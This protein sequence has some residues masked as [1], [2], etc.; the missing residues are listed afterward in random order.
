MLALIKDGHP[1]SVKFNVT[2]NMY[3]QVDHF[4]I[5]GVYKSSASICNDTGAEKELNH[6]SEK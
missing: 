4:Q 1:L 6:F 2:K 3:N 5:A